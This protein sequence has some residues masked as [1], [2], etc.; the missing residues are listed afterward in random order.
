MTKQLQKYQNQTGKRETFKPCLMKYPQW[1]DVP[2]TRIRLR[3]NENG[4][5]L[6][7]DIRV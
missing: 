2:G 1:N 4:I 3:I 7:Y 6:E 5:V